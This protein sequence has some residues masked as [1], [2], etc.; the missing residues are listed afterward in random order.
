MKNNYLLEDNSLYRF[1]IM[2]FGYKGL[3]MKIH[4]N[5]EKNLILIE[6]DIDEKEWNNI[7]YRAKCMKQSEET[8]MLIVTEEEA[9]DFNLM[10]ALKYFYK[11]NAFVIY[12]K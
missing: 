9:S 10:E 11:S 6:T 8:G 1:L 12:Q 7:L 5:K 2:I 4:K 3:N